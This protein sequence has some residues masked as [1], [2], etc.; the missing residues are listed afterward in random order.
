MRKEVLGLVA[1]SKERE[2]MTQIFASGRMA[3][4]ITTLER[5]SVCSPGR[6]MLC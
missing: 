5:F 2:S 4:K 1:A 3:H 6:E